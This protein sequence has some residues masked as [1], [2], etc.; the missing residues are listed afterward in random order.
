MAYI[1]GNCRSNLHFTDDIC[2]A[3]ESSDD[4]QQ[5]VD[6]IYLAGIKFGLRINCSE[7]EVQCIE[8]E[9]NIR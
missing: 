9:P 8:R 6:N 3:A 4:L 5:L 2:M 1:P 7:T